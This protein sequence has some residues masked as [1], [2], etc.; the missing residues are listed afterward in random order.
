[1]RN[2][3]IASALAAA[4]I[5]AGALPSQAASVT[6]TTDN[7]GYGYHRMMDHPYHRPYYRHHLPPRR[8][9]DDCFTRTERI[10]HHGR[11]VIKETRVC[12]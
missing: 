11:T 2:I 3:V 9:S 8:I 12:R 1:M 7:G 5:F 6:I 4:T 10:H